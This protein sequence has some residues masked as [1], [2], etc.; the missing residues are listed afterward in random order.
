M[1][2]EEDITESEAVTPKIREE[3]DEFVRAAATASGA[4]KTDL[5]LSWRSDQVS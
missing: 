2:Q 4:D 1:E 3:E 5:T